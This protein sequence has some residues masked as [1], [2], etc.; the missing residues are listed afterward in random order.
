MEQL[1][2]DSSLAE[3]REVLCDRFLADP[4]V[5]SNPRSNRCWLECFQQRGDYLVLGT[6]SGD[7]IAAAA[8][9]QRLWNLRELL[10]AFIGPSYGLSITLNSADLPDALIELPTIAPAVVNFRGDRRFDGQ[11]ARA[12]QQ[13]CE[14]VQESQL[15]S[16]SLGETLPSALRNFFM[17]VRVGNRSEAEET[18]ETLRDVYHLS[19]SNVDNLRIQMLAEWHCWRE[20]VGLPRLEEVTASPRPPLVGR[21]VLR[22]F[23]EERLVPH[24]TD[25]KFDVAR[26]VFQR[27]VLPKLGCL[28]DTRISRTD[29]F[30]LN[31]FAYAAVVANNKRQLNEILAEAQNAG[32]DIKSLEAIAKLADPSA[33]IDETPTTGDIQE[34]V[35]LYEQ[36]DVDAAL[37]IVDLLPVSREKT[38]LL[39][40]CAYAV[41]SLE[42]VH[43]ALSSVEELDPREATNLRNHP[44]WK[45]LL[46]ELNLLATTSSASVPLNWKEWFE[47]LAQESNESLIQV[48]SQGSEEWPPTGLDPHRIATCLQTTWP[49][50]A[51]YILRCSIPHLWRFLQRF[52]DFPNRLHAPVYTSL[53]DFLAYE[54]NGNRSDLF[55]LAEVLH[56]RLETGINSSD[57]VDAIHLLTEVWTTVSSPE[58]IEWWLEVLEVLADEPCGNQQERETLLWSWPNITRRT[59]LR[60][61]TADLEVLESVCRQLNCESAFQAVHQSI[62]ESEEDVPNET[63]I[64]QRLAGKAIGVYTLTVTAAHRFRDFLS[65]ACPDCTVVLNH[66]MVSTG[67]LESMARSCDLVVVVKR[68]A[69]HAATDGIARIRRGLP[70]IHPVGKGT[71]SMLRSLKEYLGSE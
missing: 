44:K 49:A 64:W 23:Y 18:L 34:A 15:P 67:A 55:V 9:E 19:N 61:S 7:W 57:Y 39:L 37:N 12:V 26:D 51:H 2:S 6:P 42:I 8:D 71:A 1:M 60:L 56:T 28:T 50:Q 38:T 35:L 41:Q 31:V 40:D 68:S 63:D 14:L 4:Q 27:E 22:A 5:T 53:F 52:D 11:I 69:Q 32:L 43:K 59:L 3:A 17:A 65:N 16:L 54:N 30:T 20:I 47:R 36:G 13:I 66:D 33:S 24:E 62:G 25:G 70:T 46:A 21:S 58:R 45:R 29:P 10:T 48:A